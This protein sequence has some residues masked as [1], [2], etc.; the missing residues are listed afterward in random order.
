MIEVNGTTSS[1]T[2]DPITPRDAAR[3]ALYFAA[4][5]E[6]FPIF[7]E[8]AIRCAI[9]PEGKEWAR[10]LTLDSLRNAAIIVAN[11]DGKIIFP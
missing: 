1:G 10:T 3:Y 2:T 9:S 5:T 11:L 6:T 7:K 4:E 8:W